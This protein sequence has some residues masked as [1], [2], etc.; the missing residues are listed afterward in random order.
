MTEHDLKTWPEYF[1][2][3]Y[4]GIKRFEY[5]KNDRNFKEGDILHLRE[6]KSGSQRYTGRELKAR[7]EYILHGGVFD[8]P[9]EWCIMSIFII[10]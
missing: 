7:I 2:P 6:W 10:G 9:K 4:E 1:Q 5:R 8:L 3:M